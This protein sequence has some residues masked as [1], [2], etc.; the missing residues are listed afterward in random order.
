MSSRATRSY[1]MQRVTGVVMIPISIWILFFLLPKTGGVIFHQDEGRNQALYQIF[2][3]LDS[4]TYILIFAI[5]AFYHG[6]L[7]MESVINDYIHC[8][9]MKKISIVMIYCFAIFSIVFFSV[10]SIDMHIKTLRYNEINR[11]IVYEQ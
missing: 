7:G 3:G 8:N 2:R 11:S 1:L 10:F 5:C 6:I 9:V 4:I